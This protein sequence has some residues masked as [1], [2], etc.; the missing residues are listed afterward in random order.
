[1]ITPPSS[2]RPPHSGHLLIIAVVLVALLFGALNGRAASPSV[3]D[4]RADLIKWEGLKLTQYGRGQR[5]PALVGIGHKLTRAELVAH[6]STQYTTMEVDALFYHDLARSIEAARRVFHTF[7]EQSA[8]VQMVLVG[9]AFTCGPKGLTKW[10][11]LQWAV[12]HGYADLAQ[13]TLSISLW[14]QQVSPARAS[15][16]RAVLGRL[17]FTPRH[18]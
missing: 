14:Y 5:E 1:M 9:L 8:E 17:H 15:W 7:D 3:A 12:D 13:T 18:P 11:V 10:M 16:Y 4:Y 6:P 2:H